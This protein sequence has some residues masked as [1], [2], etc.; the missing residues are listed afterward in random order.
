MDMTNVFDKLIALQEILAEKYEIE[1]KIENA[2][3]DL[4]LQDGSNEGRIYQYKHSL[5]R[6]KG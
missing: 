4:G 6:G 3:K 1:S 5:R 2:P